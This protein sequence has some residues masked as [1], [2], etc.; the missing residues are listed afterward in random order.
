[1]KLETNLKHPWTSRV[2][3]LERYLAASRA[4]EERLRKLILLERL[5]DCSWGNGG[6][7]GDYCTCDLA[8]R[9][10]ALAETEEGT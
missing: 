4:R 2:S 10:A 8:M 5:A 9:R 1:V 6:P 7:E 3:A